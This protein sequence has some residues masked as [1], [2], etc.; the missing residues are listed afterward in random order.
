MDSEVNRLKGELHEAERTIGSLRAGLEKAWDRG[1]RLLA[2]LEAIEWVEM[3]DM[4]YD[5]EV[6]SRCP[7]CDGEQFQGHKPDCQRQ[8]ALAVR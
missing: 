6:E 8:D 1:G 4:F 3:P 5:R 2:A 7:W